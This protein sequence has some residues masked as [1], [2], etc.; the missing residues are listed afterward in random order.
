MDRQKLTTLLEEHGVDLNLWG[1]G[2]AKTLNHLLSELDAGETTLRKQGDGLVRVTDGVVLNVFYNNKVRSWLKEKCQVFTDGRVKERDLTTS[3]G[4]KKSAHE[5]LTAAAY[6]ALREELKIHDQLTLWPQP[7]HQKGPVPSISFPGLDTIYTFG[8]FDVYLPEH[9]YKPDGY[10][11]VQP[12][13]TNYFVWVEQRIVEAAI[14]YQGQVYRGRRHNEI[15]NTMVKKHGL[16]PPFRGRIEGFVDN[17]C[18]G[19]FLNRQE[20]A[21]VA[22]ACG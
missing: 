2:G 10:V 22:L 16:V 6:R 1:T 13:K 20:A 5:S 3:I 18:G 14:R 7:D 4:E 9:L 17:H 19:N 11:E 8:V 15:I 12:D 21:V